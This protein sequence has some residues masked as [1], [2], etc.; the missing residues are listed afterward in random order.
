MLKLDRRFERVLGLLLFKVEVVA[1]V[2]KGAVEVGVPSVLEDVVA[3][4]AE[5][6]RLILDE[7][8]TRCVRVFFWPRVGGR[9]QRDEVTLDMYI[10]SLDIMSQRKLACF[11]DSL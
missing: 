1:E 11:L 4:G 10:A 6:T 8:E 3:A 5:T 7:D 2:A 9:N